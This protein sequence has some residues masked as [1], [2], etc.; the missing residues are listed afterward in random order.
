MIKR[1]ERLSRIYS[2]MK[3]RCYNSKMPNFKYYGARGI[4]VCDEWRN[5]SQSFYQWAILNGY[6][7]ELT[8]D[9]ID[10]SGNYEP[11]NCRWVTAKEQSNHR[12]NN[13]ILS[14]NGE[15]HT[16]SE[17]SEITGIKQHVIRNRLIR[18]WSI[19]NVLTRK[20]GKY[21]HKD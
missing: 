20:V 19:E 14:F 4:A 13:I 7:E 21:V 2:M 6:K 1:T 18:G 3:Q 8:L 12:S 15:N 11:S 9:R 16:I 5:D 10:N 17:W